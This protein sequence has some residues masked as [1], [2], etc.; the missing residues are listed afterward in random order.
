VNNS[1]SAAENMP[2]KWIRLEVKDLD[3]VIEFR[4]TDSGF[5]ISAEVEKKIFDPFF[6][7]KD[8]GQGAGL[9]L[10]ISKGIID[11]HGGK[12]GLDR[13]ST[14]TCFYIQIPKKFAI[15]IAS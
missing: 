14:N 8:F 5:G 3:Q 15:K 13:S 12:I 9:G 11:Q 10:S 6:T 4:I 1:S 2:V 7:T